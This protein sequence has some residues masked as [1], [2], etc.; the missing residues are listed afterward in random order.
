MAVPYRLAGEIRIRIRYKTLKGPWFDYLLVSPEEMEAIVSAAKYATI[1]RQATRLSWKR[2]EHSKQ[3][4][5]K[6][7]L[8]SVFS[9]EALAIIW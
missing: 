6:L 1:Q 4:C 9:V 3:K 5:A 7:L 2:N 8:T